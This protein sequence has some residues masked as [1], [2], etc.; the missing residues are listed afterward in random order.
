MGYSPWGCTELDMTERLH[1]HFQ[2]KTGILKKL[3]VSSVGNIFIKGL[4]S[5]KLE[6]LRIIIHLGDIFLTTNS[7]TI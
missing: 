3:E 5:A 4:L 2:A 7:S 6:V 1:L